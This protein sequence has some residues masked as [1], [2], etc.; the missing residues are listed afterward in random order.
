MIQRL[1][2]PVIGG[3]EAIRYKHLIDWIASL[4]LAMTGG[5]G[6]LSP[7]LWGGGEVDCFFNL[8]ILLTFA[9]QKNR[10][11]GKTVEKDCNQGW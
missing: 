3:H 5:T 4:L 8:V 1:K 6:I 7:L 9:I 10:S 2:T 11:N